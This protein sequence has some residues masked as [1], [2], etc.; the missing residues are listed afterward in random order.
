MCA[1]KVGVFVLTVFLFLIFTSCRSTKKLV[2]EVSSG[3]EIIT[4]DGKIVGSMVQSAAIIRES[5]IFMSDSVAYRIEII[6]YD[7]DREILPTGKPPVKKETA[8]N[9]YQKTGTNSKD[10]EYLV[11]RLDSQIQKNLSIEHTNDTRTELLNE[12]NNTT[13]ISKLLKGVASI[14]LFGVLLGLIFYAVYK[15]LRK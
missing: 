1:K 12:K 4:A 13:V 7:S 6:E 15:R 9:L 10:N 11:S 3:H 14:V 5:Q 8:I 2:T